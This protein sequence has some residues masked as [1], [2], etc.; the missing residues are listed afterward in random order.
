MNRVL[1][2]EFFFV[3]VTSFS[4]KPVTAIPSKGRSGCWKMN[5][6]MNFL[7]P[8][9]L[10]VPSGLRYSGHTSMC[11]SMPVSSMSSS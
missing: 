7:S 4:T 11:S 8:W 10:I 1:V 9:N 5:C 2:F 6:T 3:T